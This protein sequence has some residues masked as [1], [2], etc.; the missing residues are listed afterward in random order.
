MVEIQQLI[1][2]GKINGGFDASDQEI[3]KIIND[4]IE[5]YISRYKFGLSKDQKKYLIEECTENILKKIE[6][7]SKL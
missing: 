4:K 1:I 6:L 5:E 2:K 3:I 7:D